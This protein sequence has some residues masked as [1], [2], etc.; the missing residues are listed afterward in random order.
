MLQL[1]QPGGSPAFAAA[2]LDFGSVCPARTVLTPSQ[3]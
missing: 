1:A 3:A 2:H